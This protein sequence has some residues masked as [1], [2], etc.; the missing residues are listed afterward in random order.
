LYHAFREAPK[1][2]SKIILNDR[3]LGELKSFLCSLPT[4]HGY[5]QF[6][7]IFPAHRLLLKDIASYLEISPGRMSEIRKNSQ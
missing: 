1:L 7:Q 5:V 4:A 3:N 6:Q 2:S